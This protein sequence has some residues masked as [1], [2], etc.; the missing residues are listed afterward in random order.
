MYAG[1]KRN[2]KPIKK[3]IIANA[4]QG[5]HIFHAHTWNFC[6]KIAFNVDVVVVFLYFSRVIL[7]I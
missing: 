1:W 2:V 5:F 4:S 7:L 3:N 6:L